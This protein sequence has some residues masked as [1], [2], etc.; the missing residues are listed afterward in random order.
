MKHNLGIRRFLLRGL[1]KV[2]TEG[3]WIALGCNLTRL[4]GHLNAS[5]VSWN[6]E[7]PFPPRVLKVA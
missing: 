3:T 1:R 5:P 7:R 6:A 4:F 2:R